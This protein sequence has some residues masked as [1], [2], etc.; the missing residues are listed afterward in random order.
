MKSGHN[1]FKKF[2]LLNSQKFLTAFVK[3]ANIYNCVGRKRIW[4]KKARNPVFMRVSQPDTCPRQ[5]KK[6]ENNAYF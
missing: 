4:P 6:G 3:Y 2:F 5:R 1:S